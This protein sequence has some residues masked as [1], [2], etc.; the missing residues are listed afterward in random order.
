MKLNTFTY[1]F[2]I[3]NS[4][5]QKN[6]D[7]IFI[8]FEDSDDNLIKRLDIPYNNDISYITLD[9]ECKQIIF[10]GH[11]KGEWDDLRV[12]LKG[13]DC[14]VNDFSDLVLP[15]C[16]FNKNIPVPIN[17]LNSKITFVFID[18]THENEIKKI[19]HLY[20][21]IG[22]TNIKI[23]NNKNYDINPIFNEQEY[24]NFIINDLYKFI[25]TDYV[26]ISNWDSFAVNFNMFFKEFFS[27]DYLGLKN[28]LKFNLISKKFLISIS[29]LFKNKQTKFKLKKYKKDLLKLNL[30]LPDKQID[31]LFSTHTD[32]FSSH[33]GFC[34][35]NIQ[36]LPLQAK[37][38]FNKKFHHSGDLGDL[39]FSI[40]TIK[41][42]GGGVLHISND[43]RYFLK[44]SSF[45]N[46][47]INQ[48]IDFLKHQDFIIDVFINQNLPCDID[49]DLNKFRRKQLLQ[50]NGLLNKDEEDDFKKNWPN[51]TLTKLHLEEF[52]CDFN[53]D[54]EPWLKWNRKIVYYNKPIIINRTERYLNP[55]FP[56]K[57]IIDKYADYCYFVGSKIE[58]N[59]FCKEF[60]V[61]DYLNTPSIISLVETILGSKLV[62]GNMSFPTAL[63]EGFKHNCLV[64]SGIDVRSNNYERHNIFVPNPD[65]I[66][67][68]EVFKFIEEYV[69][70]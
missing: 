52:N 31:S 21:S 43:M 22:L 63:C 10:L 41:A 12:E 55:D 53:W 15:E 19:T 51:S 46:K 58:Y 42:L 39:I 3:P 60:G 59:N 24:I 13:H 70:F 28:N 40:P 37:Q 36:N 2:K 65:N 62:I 69:H 30:K 6:Y 38:F 9:K 20:N 33:F 67:I 49:Y 17:E 8:G 61:V 54:I 23:F 32:Y 64:E 1:K 18:E 68:E 14:L 25:D 27:Y 34:G 48:L 7:F 5:K 11:I 45:S 66:N 26:L 57:P 16:D 4:F 44:R 35:F 50:Y 29:S 47:I 56:W